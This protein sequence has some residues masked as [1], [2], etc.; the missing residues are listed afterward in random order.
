MCRVGKRCSWYLNHQK[1]YN[2]KRRAR[3]AASKKAK[4]EGITMQEAMI[5]LYGND[6]MM[7]G[8]TDPKATALAHKKFLSENN[9]LSLTQDGD[10]DFAKKIADMTTKEYNSSEEA[11]KEFEKAKQEAASKW[12][13][14]YIPPKAG[15]DASGL[16]V[17]PENIGRDWSDAPVVGN[18]IAPYVD[19]M[20]LVN[21]PSNIENVDHS[22][23]KY[24]APRTVSG[25]IDPDLLNENSWKNFGLKSDED[26]N[27]YLYGSEKSE[28]TYER[29]SED[30]MRGMSLGE[31]TCCRIFTS[32][33]YQEY[34]DILYG[35]DVPSSDSFEK[36][37]DSPDAFDTEDEYYVQLLRNVSTRD[38]VKQITENLDLAMSN[39]PKKQR[40]V[41]RGIGEESKMLLDAGGVDNWLADHGQLGQTISFSSYTSTSSCISVARNMSGNDSSGMLFEI[42]TPE[43]VNVTS[44]SEY[45]SER[46]V[47]LPR[48]QTYVV[49]GHKE[50]VNDEDYPEY[51]QKVVQLVAI[52][53]KGEVLD[54]TNADE[55]PSIDSILEENKKRI[56]ARNNDPEKEETESEE[57]SD[58]WSYSGL[59]Y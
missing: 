37:N 43:G 49:V 3:Y 12:P 31:K 13:D 25:R 1:E 22:F 40:V 30:E 23:A 27:D 50:I 20:G 10:K 51:N 44:V 55:P 5:A 39:A 11:T 17:R 8:K 42:L 34:A 26:W 18:G 6:D 41:Y 57:S 54:G 2:A 21:E 33:A 48:N 19:D 58:S 53:S 59:E 45:R 15:D 24:Y 35:N 28:S 38:A 56:E 9:V 7:P 4:A 16:V 36:F 14:G 52:N 47:L 46:E 29:W 32:P